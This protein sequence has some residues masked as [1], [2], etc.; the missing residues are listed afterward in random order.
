MHRSNRIQLVAVHT[1]HQQD[2]LPWLRSLGDDDGHIPELTAPHLDALEHEALGLPRLE[3]LDVELRDDW[4]ALN[5]VSGER[6]CGLGGESPQHDQQRRQPDRDPVQ[7]KL[8]GCA[9]VPYL[10]PE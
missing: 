4:K 2:P 9:V 10:L 1:R 3:V 7:A 8:G 5:L 6:S